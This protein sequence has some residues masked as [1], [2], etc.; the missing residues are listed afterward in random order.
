MPTAAFIETSS[1]RTSSSMTEV[2]QNLQTS[3]SQD[4]LVSPAPRSPRGPNGTTA[5]MAP[6]VFSHRAC[7]AS[8]VYALGIV[9][10]ELV[11][12]RR[13]DTPARPPKALGC[14]EEL[15]GLERLYLSMT[16]DD[17]ARRPPASLVARQVAGILRARRNSN[18]RRPAQAADNPWPWILGG[19]A[20][21]GVIALASRG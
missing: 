5:Y 21:L 8:D 3:A 13:H 10:W 18:R 4:A 7:Q 6:E 9:L 19:A 1:L 12:G 2:Y 14:P 20:L 17:P 15:Q 16:D 11:N